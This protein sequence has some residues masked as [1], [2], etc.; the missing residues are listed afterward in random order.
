MQIRISGVPL[1]SLSKVFRTIIGRQLISE[2][3]ARLRQRL[4]ALDVCVL[5]W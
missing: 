2:I 3:P 5:T 4:Q 1:A